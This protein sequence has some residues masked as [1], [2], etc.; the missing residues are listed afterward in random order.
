MSCILAQ[1][2]IRS[3]QDYIFRSNQVLEIIGASEH[4]TRSWDVLLAQAK[5]AGLKV[6]SLTDHKPFE[7]ESVQKSF[8]EKTLNL[9]E[10][11][12]G[13]GNDT[14]LFDSMDSYRLANQ[15][16]SRYL[17]EEFPGMIP[18]AVCCEC[19]GDYKKDYQN[20]I[21]EA[22]MEKNRMIS[23]QSSFILPFSMMD[24]N[25][26]QPF[27]RVVHYGTETVRLTEE[28]YAKRNTGR[29]VRDTKNDVNDVKILDNMVTKRGEESLLAV[30]HAD[31]NNMGS[32]I[33]SMLGDCADYNVCVQKMREFT[34]DTANAFVTEGLEALEQCK[35]NL[36]KRYK[37]KYKEKYNSMFND[38]SF[39]CR[40]IISDGD[41]MTFICNAR[42]AMDYVKAYLESVQNYQKR[43]N[44]E[45]AY[46]SCAGICI[47]HGHY[48]FARAYSMAEQAC[49]DGAK[50]KVHIEGKIIEEGWVDFHYIHSG[51]G[52]NLVSIRDHQ[53]TAECMARPWLVTGGGEEREEHFSQLMKLDELLKTYH[54]ARTDVKT[55]GSEYESST[56]E[57]EKELNRICGHHKGLEKELNQRFGDKD[58]LLKTIYDLSEVYDLWFKTV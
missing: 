37:E 13:G 49:D 39:S 55:L 23:G 8:A 15:Q 26:F 20:L 14:I 52:G 9:V 50:K 54:V 51:I 2:T 18:M 6:C 29:K 31:G 34:A 42:F 43:H 27:S 24:R 44:S 22:E 21:A 46:S 3:K 4:I 56:S 7:M 53:G 25:S 19:T 32:K 33:S 57:G 11:F 5:K 17:L 10:L 47:F 12:R 41:D 38:G 48:P 58:R 36:Q 16:F 28:N 45:W 30:I 1:Y 40:N 35:E